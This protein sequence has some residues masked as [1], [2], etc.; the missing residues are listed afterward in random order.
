MV[1]HS[2]D[3]TPEISVYCLYILVQS[4]VNDLHT[5][6]QTRSIVY[7]SDVTV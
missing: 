5:H 6:T 1:L 4:G 2:F 7:L 3:K